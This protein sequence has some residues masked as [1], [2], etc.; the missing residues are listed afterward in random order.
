MS[1]S[2]FLAPPLSFYQQSVGG[3]LS[4]NAQWNYSY[5]PYQRKTAT[6]NSNHKRAWKATA[7]QQR[8]HSTKKIPFKSILYYLLNPRKMDLNYSSYDDFAKADEEDD[9]LGLESRRVTTVT[10][11]FREA[12]DRRDPEGFGDIPIDEVD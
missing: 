4:T 7:Q 11:L 2:N 6:N 1:T 5:S 3:G 9:E 10:R 8:K 12:L